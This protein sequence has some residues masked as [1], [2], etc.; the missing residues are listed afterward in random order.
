MLVPWLLF[1]TIPAQIHDRYL[2]FPAACAAILLAEGIGFT[3]LGIFLTGLTF[4]QTVQSAMQTNSVLA[5]RYVH[6]FFN[7]DFYRFCDTLRPDISW[8]VLAITAVFFFAAFTGRRRNL[9]LP[10]AVT[11]VPDIP[12]TPRPL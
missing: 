6:P 1:Y 3:L 2:L 10:L 4:L 5:E 9:P 12:G 7:P 11:P 8:A